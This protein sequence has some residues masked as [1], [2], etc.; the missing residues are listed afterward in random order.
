MS[1]YFVYVAEVMILSV[2]LYGLIASN[3]LF[4]KLA[5]LA[6]MQTAV[7]LLYIS[8]G[9]VG[10]DA[11]IPIYKEGTNAIYTNPLPQVLMLTAIVVG[12][13]VTAVGYTLIF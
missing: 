6:I 12:L 2:G 8:I 7:I 5:S 10:S 13:A 11:N 1:G 3:H 9:Y 4:K